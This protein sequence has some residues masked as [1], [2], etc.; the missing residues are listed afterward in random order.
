[1]QKEIKPPRLFLQFFRWFC[2]EEL[3][4]SI[5][6]DLV[7]LYHERLKKE[8]ELKADIKFIWDVLL[9][10]RPGIIGIKNKEYKTN[11]IDMFRNNLKIAR[12]TLWKNKT[13]TVINM[14]GLSIGIT[15]CL[16]I[17]LFINHEMSYDTFQPN[18]KRIGRVVMEY[19]F[20]GSEESEKGTFTST[21]VAPVF[22][23]T[24]P[25]VE[26]GIRMSK[27]AAILQLQGSPVTEPD[28]MYADSTFFDAFAFTMVQGNAKT[29]LN[30][31]NKVV[32]TESMAKKYYGDS[33]PVGQGL[34][35]GE[36]KTM[37]EV[38]GVMED[39]PYNSQFRFDFLASF[40]SLGQNQNNTYWNANYTTYLLLQDQN[41][42]GSLAEKIP[43]FMEKESAEIGANVNFTLEPFDRVHL[44][45][46][47]S[48]FVPNTSI[49]YLYMLAGVAFLILVIVCFTYINLSTAKS[50]E[51]AKEV[52]IRKVS[53]AE[54]SQLFWQFI[55]ESFLLS[56][57]SV[58]VSIVLV[59][60]FLPGF[61]NLINRQ[62]QLDDLLSPVFIGFALSLVLMLSLIAGAYPALILSRFQPMKVL[63]G[64]FK[65]TDSA[66]WLQQSLTVFQF[67]I[68]VFLIIATLIVQGQL[69][70]IQSRD[71]GYDREHIVSFP[72]GW[73]TDFQK[74]NTLKKEL[75]SNS[76][77]LEV[78]RTGSSP[79]SIYSG[80]SM[81]LPT[82]PENEVIAVNGNPVDENFI[83]VTGLELLAGSNFTEQQVRQ[84]YSEG[85]DDLTFNYI[86][87]ESAA[88]KFGWSPEE[89][90]GK[91][92]ILNDQGT[93]VGV[94]KD[95]HFQSLRNDI[96]P[97]VLF[98]A[99]WGGRLL[100]KINGENIP[101][102]LD[103]IEKT[104]NK[105]L[106]EMP[107]SYKFLDE[108]YTRM[109]QSEMQLGK[110]MNLFSTI[111]IILA[112]LG[113][114]G[115]SSYLIQQRLKEVSIRKVL[116]ASTFQILNILSG[117]FVRLVFLAILI[118]SPIAYWAMSLWLDDFVFH[119]SAPWW[120]V[121]VA[122]GVTLAIGLL[123]SGVHGIKAALSNPVKNLKSE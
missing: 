116:G 31:P 50:V 91:E 110:I 46:P 30:G 70:F 59:Y 55:G 88:A 32:L 97:L 106:P 60:L 121:A 61:N 101:E 92:M 8:G 114:F 86:I 40:S 34:E 24:F 42:F 44:H 6:G 36:D 119:I 109:Y 14:L 123:T 21:K 118:A 57:L 107:Y 80:Y 15:S 72:V 78:S 18:A 73:S 22:S 87:T 113:L 28:F 82:R 63:K 76:Q 68:S 19:S 2:S 38:T 53:G 84:T 112:C 69:N 81:N 7:E 27:S 99:S 52:G 26:K 93:V 37:Y 51:R 9:L 103:F 115:L 16:L 56:G 96:Q 108:D 29:A 94:I 49:D 71:L 83:Q 45:S 47:Y 54:P 122:A 105:V 33:D 11:H 20:L 39:Y 102:T 3:L 111:A 10:F 104:W 35:I 85:D 64:V 25:E 48:D 66:K 100:V 77:I 23:S 43:P 58:L 95:F 67:G 17:A 1:M 5:E 74:V 62:L 89:A 4:D 117:S 41:S 120:A 65:N 12:R 79:V 98:T 75:K 13:S 90:V